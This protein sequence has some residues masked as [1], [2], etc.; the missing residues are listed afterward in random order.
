MI[1]AGKEF[2]DTGNEV[3]D[4]TP[5][6]GFVPEPPKY[7][8]LNE[9]VRR[10]LDLSDFASAQGAESVEE[11]N[12]FDVPDEDDE[13]SHLERAA[14]VRMQEMESEPL[15]EQA[16]ASPPQSPTGGDAEPASS[17]GG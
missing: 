16:P 7:S 10:V 3:L 4:S 9:F 15:F 11:A 8:V 1:V 14:H 5:V 17:S 12:D 6:E 13:W 2:D